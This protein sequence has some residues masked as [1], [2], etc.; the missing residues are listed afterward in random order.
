MIRRVLFPVDFSMVSEYAFSNCIPRFFSTGVAEELILIHVAEVHHPGSTA[1]VDL[2]KIQMD[3][4]KRLEK[5][6][7]DFRDMGINVIKTIVRL[8]TPAIEIAKVAEEEDV[9]L[10]FMPSKGEHI[11]RNMLIGTTASNVARVATKPVLLVK[12]EWDKARHM[13]KCIWDARRVFDKP[14]IALDFSPCSDNIVKTVKSLF[15][16]HVRRATLVHV[17]DYGKPDETKENMKKA[18]EELEKIAK[19][20]KF[21]CDVEVDAGIASNAII[22]EAIIKGSTVI[23]VGKRGRSVVKDLLLG[24]TADSVIRKS[25]LPVLLVPC[26]Y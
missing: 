3:V 15:E 4:K 5:V 2:D 12:Y 14:L 16:D 17:V 19:E 10:I 21:E 26:R 13:V 1:Y 8:G 7:N 18:L 9:D 6:A 22:N 11:L 25:M 24:S 20:F 23:V